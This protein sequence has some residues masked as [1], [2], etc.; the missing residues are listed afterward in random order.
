MNL[1]NK[2]TLFRILMV[3]VI[4]VLLCVPLPIGETALRITVASVF[5]V[6]AIT[7]FID[8]RLA[9]RTNQ[10]TDFGK[11]LDPLADKFLIIASL[12]G[13]LYRFDA[14]RPYFI[15][16]TAIVIFR[17]F[18]VTSVR[19]M[20]AN[21]A[22]LVVA[23]SWLGKIKTLTQMTCVLIALLEPVLIPT[24]FFITHTPITLALLVIMSVMTLWSGTDYMI[25]YWPYIGKTK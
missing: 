13:I 5:F 10:V 1:P 3:P 8:G 25:R 15:W 2:L 17:E 14:L 20:A 6:T 11:F 23:A 24:E 9:R 21:K 4:L 7:D 18:T 22:G 19:M 12:L 16:A